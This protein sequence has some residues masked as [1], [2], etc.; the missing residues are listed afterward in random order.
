M[1]AVY[2]MVMLH[3]IKISVID[4]NNLSPRGRQKSSQL[5]FLL[6]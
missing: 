2:K 5:S 4:G 1:I 6:I 3:Y